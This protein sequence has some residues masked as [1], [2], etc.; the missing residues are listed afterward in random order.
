VLLSLF[1]QP[2]HP[3]AKLVTVIALVEYSVA[4]VFGVVFGILVGLIKIAGFSVRS[5]FEELLIRAAWLAVFAVAAFATYQ[6]WRNLFYTPRPKP[7]AGV[8]GQPRH[9]VPGTY[10]GQPGYGPPAPGQPA[11]GQPGF[12]QPGQPGQHGFGQPPFG[13]PPFGQ[14]PFGQ[15]PF[16]QPPFGQP[17]F[18]QPGQPA[19]AVQPDP[20]QPGF[21]QPVSGAPGTPPGAYAP[22]PGQR[23]GTYTPEPGPGT[24]SA[25]VAPSSPPAAGPAEPAEYSAFTEPT[26][27]VPQHEAATATPEPQQSETDGDRTQIVSDERPGYGPADQNPPRR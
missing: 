22:A 25:P 15:P 5:A 7:Q 17:P 21:S 27:V 24:Y 13:Q 19:H 8:Y 16:G 3:Q 6:I 10:P 1:V 2:R 18:G 9:G 26:Q 12:G 20:G 23:P 11:P 14:P 4:A